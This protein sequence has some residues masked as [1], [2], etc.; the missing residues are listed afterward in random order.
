MPGSAA[1]AAGLKAGDI[2]QSVGGVPVASSAEFSERI[3]RL[4][5]G[6]KVEVAYL[7]GN[8][9][10]NVNVTLKGAET[11]NTVAN[12]SS[13]SGRGLQAKLGATFAPLPGNIKERYRLRAGLVITDMERGGFFDSAGI[14]RGTIITSVNGRPVN[15]PADLDAALGAT[16]NGMVRLDGMTPDGTG[17]VFNF[18]LGA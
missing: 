10:N 16:R 1:A 2:I 12:E 11:G 13:S 5:P 3:G 17:F 15:T 6:D 8:R 18:P 7:R 9:K 4:Q 14:P